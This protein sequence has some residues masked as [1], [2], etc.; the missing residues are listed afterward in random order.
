MFRLSHELAMQQLL[1]PS[2]FLSVTS[3]N[4]QAV[5]PKAELQSSDD[6]LSCISKGHVSGFSLS[7]FVLLDRMWLY[8]KTWVNICR[9]MDAER[10]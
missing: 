3:G 7:V 8:R 10:S 5:N 6:G 4:N 1:V 2:A 9:G